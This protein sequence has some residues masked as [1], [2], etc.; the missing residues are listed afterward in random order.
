MRGRKSAQPA[1]FTA[2]RNCGIA[3]TCAG[4][5]HSIS[6]AHHPLWPIQTTLALSCLVYKDTKHKA[7]F[8][9]YSM[10]NNLAGNLANTCKVR[11]L[12]TRGAFR[13]TP[14]SSSTLQT[15][16]S[17]VLSQEWVLAAHGYIQLSQRSPQLF[18]NCFCISPKPCRAIQV[19]APP[20]VLQTGMGH[21]KR[22]DMSSRAG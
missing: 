18:P 20:E 10:W 3:F 11:L 1:W 9:Q 15:S 16:A 4:V 13:R 2:P 12:E 6:S 5:Q 21:L 17:N 19:K 14:I 7:F 8:F 22:V